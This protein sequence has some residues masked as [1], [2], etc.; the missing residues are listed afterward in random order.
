MCAFA[1]VDVLVIFISMYTKLSLQVNRNWKFT[2]IDPG[3]PT[4]K[5]QVVSAFY[6]QDTD[7][8]KPW[9][10]RREGGGGGRGG[11]EL[12][13]WTFSGNYM[14]NKMDRKNYWGKF[15]V[16]RVT[17]RG[18]R[19]WIDCREDTSS[20]QVVR[21]SS[22][23]KETWCDQGSPWWKVKYI[24]TWS[25]KSY[26]HSLWKCLHLYG[27]IV[28]YTLIHRH[29]LTHMQTHTVLGIQTQFLGS[30]N[31]KNSFPSPLT[32]TQTN[33]TTITHTT[34][35]RT[36]HTHTHNIHTHY[37]HTQH[38]H[39]QHIHNIHTHTHTHTTNLFT[40]WSSSCV[41]ISS[42]RTL[43]ITQHSILVY[44]VW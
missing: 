24:E 37:I 34:Y 9:D 10:F 2:P 6:K 23:D 5:I 18:R 35:T 21:I 25:F 41:V 31:V 3:C 39:M 40:T 38:T 17:I 16:R 33:P 27:A 7:C 1:V 43:G 36:Q 12:I 20:L 13:K 15:I 4:S 32:Y 14:K 30:I 19:G 11:G 8:V 44:W 22:E 26:N 42:T 28:K 29:I